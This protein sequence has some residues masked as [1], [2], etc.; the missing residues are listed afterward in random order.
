VDDGVT[1]LSTSAGL[2]SAQVP[3]ALRRVRRSSARR[4]IAATAIIVAVIVT[5]SED[6]PV[7]KLWRF[8]IGR[9]SSLRV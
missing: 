9:P 3:V 6:G 8:N 2:T 7:A 4:R 5:T 1:V